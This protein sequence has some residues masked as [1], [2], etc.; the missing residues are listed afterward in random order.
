MKTPERKLTVLVGDHQ[1]LA[2]RS[3]LKVKCFILSSF[4]SST[5]L[6][7]W[8]A[9]SRIDCSQ[10]QIKSLFR[11]SIYY[12]NSGANISFY[13][14]TCPKLCLFLELVGIKLML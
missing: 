13:N 14:I 10:E 9:F 6:V 4:E 5:N 11:A 1:G 2:S 7:P 8:L 12:K 3:S